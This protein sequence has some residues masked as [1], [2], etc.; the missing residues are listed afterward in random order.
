MRM[1][2]VIP[3]ALEL[4]ATD[5]DFLKFLVAHLAPFGIVAFVE[6]SMNLQPFRRSCRA[7]QIHYD[8]VCLQG[9][10]SP[11]VRDVAEQPMFDRM[12][13]TMGSWRVYTVSR[14]IVMFRKNLVMLFRIAFR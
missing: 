10:A 2:F 3:I 13:P 6:P 9:N 5:A 1:D 4:V 14:S 11:V 7:D 12:H 8:L